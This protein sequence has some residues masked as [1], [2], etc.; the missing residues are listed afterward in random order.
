MKS[1]TEILKKEYNELIYLMKT[2]GLNSR[3]SNKQRKKLHQL[4]KKWNESD[5]R[6]VVGVMP[7]LP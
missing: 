4:I 5:K 7:S 6:R 3:E 1:K 2:T